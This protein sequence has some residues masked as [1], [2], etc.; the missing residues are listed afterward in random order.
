MAVLSKHKPLSVAKTLPG[1]PDPSIVKGRIITLEFE[2][3]YVIGTYVVNAG[4]GLKAGHYKL[5]LLP[6]INQPPL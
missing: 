3:C 2:K 4:M 1:H 6:S 5:H